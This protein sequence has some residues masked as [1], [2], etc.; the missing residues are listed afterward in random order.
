MR[1]EWSREGKEE[2]TREKKKICMYS[3]LCIIILFF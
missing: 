1:I 3:I 2:K